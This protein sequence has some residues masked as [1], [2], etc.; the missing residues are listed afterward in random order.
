[1]A[2]SKSSL[3]K[4]RFGY[5]NSRKKA[6][7]NRWRFFF[8][9]VERI[10]GTENKFFLELEFLNPWLSPSEVQLGFKPRINI[11]TD[12]LQYA[13]AGTKAAENLVSE[14]L[15][16]PSYIVVRIGMIGQSPKQLCA[17][18]N[19]QETVIAAKP[20]SIQVANKIFTENKLS[21][22]IS[23]TEE[24]KQK[25]PELFSESGFAKWDL[26]YEIQKDFSD[27][28]KN[29]SEVWF[30]FG[31]KTFFTGF[32]S[33]DGA[34]YI[35]DSR[36][37]LGYTERYWS[38]SYP[39]EWFHISS[40]SMSSLISGKTL[41]DSSFAVQGKFEDRISFISDFEG[42]EIT[43]TADSPKR[44]YSNVFDCIQTPESEESDENKLHWSVSINS[45]LWV[46]DIDIF[47]KLTDLYNRTLEAPE[48]NRKVMNVVQSGTGVGEI[49]LFKRIRNDLEQIEYAKITK[50]VC[51]FG[52]TEEGS[53]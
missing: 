18:H 11:S 44:A 32:V 26:T 2:V 13:L 45:K 16:K 38:K 31:I 42:S 50:A 40:T 28:Y 12:D 24:E 15:V 39:E 37:G 46:I 51:E 27:G 8:N 52:H 4:S 25:H 5:T 1:M 49:K 7:L 3:K 20:F 43:F 17:Y 22:F 19:Q 23:I 10:S 48:G 30:P 33:F 6:N 47:C 53:L 41:F 34:D 35:I 29:K 36:K 9:G 21:G 14:E